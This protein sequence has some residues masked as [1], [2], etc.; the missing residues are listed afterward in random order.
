MNRTQ[1]RSHFAGGGLVV[2]P[3]IH[4][5]D[6]EQT[7]LNVGLAL[8]AGCPGV[9]LINHDFGVAEFLPILHEVRQA[10]PNAWIGV[11]FLAVTGLD[12]F[13]KLAE[14]AANGTRIDAYWAD[15]ARID[16]RRPRD[17]QPEA[18]Q[19]A[20]TRRQSGWDGI[21]LGGTAFKKQREVA[22]A[23][24]ATSARIAC[25]FMDVVM[26]SG[27]ATGQAADM[28]KIETFRESCG[29]TPLGLASGVTPENVAR[30]GQF[31]D[32][33][34]VSTGINKDNDFYNIDPD[35]LADL[36]S[37]KDGHNPFE[38]HD[39]GKTR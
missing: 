14:L 16:E 10:Y 31:V 39:N 26:T 23:D 11:N 20:E 33:V 30:Y 17:D 34:L 24:Y 25:N 12:A 13:P 4:V 8:D 18:S 9:F 6:A 38:E 7:K 35:R 15:D 1:L 5:I 28:G 2:F 37:R 21:Y 29:D 36:M 22:P 3:V 19:I 27:V 32:V